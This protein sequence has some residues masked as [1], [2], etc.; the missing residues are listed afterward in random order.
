MMNEKSNYDLLIGKLDQFTRKF[1][2]NQIIRGLLYS[3]AILVAMFILFSVLEHYLY[4]EKNVRKLI[5]FGY[6]ASALSVL[7]LF[8]FK[9][10]LNYFQLGSRISHEK[11]RSHQRQYQSE[12]R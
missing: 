6:I 2:L 9:P 11:P 12:V 10:L 7:G 3:V 8:V 4:F 1:Y 5:F